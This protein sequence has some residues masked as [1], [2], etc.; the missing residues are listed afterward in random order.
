MIDRP[1]YINQ[2]QRLRDLDIIKVLTGVRRCGKSTIL[3]LFSEQLLS[4]GVS[5]D[6]IHM[7]N[8]EDLSLQQMNYLDI[9]RSLQSALVPGK[10]NYVFLDEVQQLAHFEKILDSLFIL[11]N[12]DL[13]VTG[14]NAFLL[15]SE[16]ATLLSGRYIEVHVLPLSF[17]ELVSSRESE[18][19][20]LSDLDGTVVNQRFERYLNYGGFPFAAAIADEMTY[21]DYMTGIVDTVLVKDIL[22]RRQRGNAR[23]VQG[24]AKF[25]VDV[26]GNLVNPRKIANTLTSSGIKTTADTVADYLK[27]FEDSYL[28]YRC[29]RYDIAGKKYLSINSKMYPADGGLRQALLGSKR[30]NRGSQLETIVFLELRRRGYDV[31]VGT[32]QGGEVDFIARKNGVTE[33]YQ[34]SATLKDENTYRREIASLKVIKDNFRKII[35]TEDSGAYD[36]QGIEQINVI[37]WLLA[38]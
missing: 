7:M 10:T 34:V 21:R 35:L 15:S 5:A 27:D 28:F 16:L 32:L 14:S 30:P 11:N 2:L 29:D 31:Y 26:A 4:E 25:L 8:F 6:R 36:D 3:S 9:Y 33:Y 12:V 19:T 22:S 13:Y 18:S 1:S 23:L 17:A 37:D 38:Q 24:M 20:K